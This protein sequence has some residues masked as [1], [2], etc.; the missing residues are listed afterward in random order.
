METLTLVK[1]QTKSLL[2]VLTIIF[3]IMSSYAEVATNEY[4]SLVIVKVAGLN[5]DS[6]NK[7][8]EGISKETSLTLE[9]SCFESDVIVIKYKHT[10]SDK[11]DVQH[12]ISNKLKKWIGKT[13]VEFIHIDMVLGGSSKC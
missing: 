2:L 4:S 5:G 10:F 1:K 11:G 12:F 13:K 6:Y 9:Y 7:I 3:G 8:A